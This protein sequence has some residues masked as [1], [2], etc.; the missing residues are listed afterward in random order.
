MEDI[1]HQ[2]E[3][4]QHGKGRCR[5]VKTGEKKRGFP[6]IMGKGTVRMTVV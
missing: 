1:F 4:G 5:G 3:G 6:R 2:N